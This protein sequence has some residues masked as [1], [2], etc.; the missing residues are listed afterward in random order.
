[1]SS[2]PTDGGVTVN[3]D[4]SFTYTPDPSFTGTDSFTYTVSDGAAQSAAATV[5]LTVTAAPNQ[6]PV[7]NNDTYSTPQDTDL[8]VA[9]PRGMSND[10]DPEG[11]ALRISTIVSQPVNGVLSPSLLGG[12]A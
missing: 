8:V 5:Q 1:M 3:P 10:L 4:G 2:L 12:L 6:P 7:A 11:S 9:G